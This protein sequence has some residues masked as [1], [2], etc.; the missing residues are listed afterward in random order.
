MI[1]W[2]QILQATVTIQTTDSDAPP[3]GTGFVAPIYRPG[4]TETKFIATAAH[5]VA[6]ARVLGSAIEVMDV[7]G[8]RYSASIEYCG[9]RIPGLDV[10]IL[11]LDS[12]KP[13]LPTLP[14]TAI[15]EPVEIIAIGSPTLLETKFTALEGRCLGLQKHKTS[16]APVLDL[17]VPS[18]NAVVP[19][20][21]ATKRPYDLWGG[22]SGA[23]ILARHRD[24]A[25]YTCVIGLLTRIAQ[26]GRA[27]RCYGVP[28][29]AIERACRAAKLEIDISQLEVP[30][31][32]LDHAM[33]VESLRGLESYDRE[34]EAWRTIS[35]LFY[36]GLGS[37][38]LLQSIV[39]G[40]KRLRLE[41]ADV[42]LVEFF[43]ARLFLKRG[44][45]DA[46]LGALDRA[47]RQADLAGA[48]TRARVRALV[49]ARRGPELLRNRSHSTLLHTFEDARNAL[50]ELRGVDDRYIRG[51][52]ASLIGWQSTKLISMG[53]PE[54]SGAVV[55]YLRHSIERHRGLYE[56]NPIELAKQDVVVT[57]LQSLGILTGVIA[58]RDS[59]GEL[60][61]LADVGFKQSFKRKNSI[62]FAQMLLLRA[63]AYWIIGDHQ[64]SRRLLAIVGLLL[65]AGGITLAHEGVG[66]LAEV[67]GRLSPQ[68]YAL[69]NL[70][71]GGDER[72][73]P[74]Y[75]TA[76]AHLL[77]YI[78]EARET[79]RNVR[80][81]SLFE[82]S[83]DLLG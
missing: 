17:D 83:P 81:E 2:G 14:C 19:S 20:G 6:E 23:P 1:P 18:I 22:L 78:S 36:S 71:A 13:G 4:Q 21:T 72:V 16:G 64:Y 24:G 5:L 28:L 33:T 10:A 62:F 31:H 80:W 3:L 35:N 76:S 25:G 38:V 69:L 57:A 46:G 56:R 47:E 75:A 48:A 79:I 70:C 7:T 59:T 40:A 73:G 41:P 63:M 65:K 67:L 68:A 53:R 50:T 45:F 29:A 49:A 34:I 11:E 37:D 54:D 32:E 43:R 12:P 55:S 74:T 60:L 61:S 77:P 15:E 27:G 82:L 8:C 66:Q 51:E 9:D 30:S 58:T 42:A 39:A 44:L 26:D 52:L